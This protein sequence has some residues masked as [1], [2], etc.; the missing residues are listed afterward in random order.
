[1]RYRSRRRPT[2][3][4]AYS[5]GELEALIQSAGLRVQWLRPG[6]YPGGSPITGQD[7]LLLG[8]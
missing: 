1:V 2:A 6:Y 8:H 4:V 3:A 5:R 7:T